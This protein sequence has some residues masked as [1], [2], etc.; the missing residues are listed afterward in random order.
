MA[1]QKI[2]RSLP[3]GLR[4]RDGYYSYRDPVDGKEYGLGRNKREAVAQAM[5]AN[6][7][8]RT[9]VSL[10][11]RINGADMTWSNWC[12]TFEKLRE[13]RKRSDNTIRQDRSKMNRLRKCFGS[14]RSA[15]GITTK[16]VAAVLKAIKAEGK[17][18]MAQSF[19]SFLI[20]CFDRMVAQG[21]RTDNP[22]RVTDTIDVEVKRARLTLEV[23]MRVY[24]GTELAWL[25]NAMA[26]ALVSGQDRDSIAFAEFS[27]FRDGFWWNERSKTKARIKIPLRV[28]LDVFGMSLEEVLRQCRQTG[29][30]SRHPVHQ[31]ERGKGAR[32]GKKMHEDTITRTFTAEIL[33]LGI[34]W[35]KKTHPTFYEIRSL[36]TRLY[37]MQRS[38]VN[39]KAMATEGKGDENAE[40]VEVTIDD[41]V[42][43][44][45]LLGHTEAETTEIYRD[46]RGEWVEADLGSKK[47]KTKRKPAP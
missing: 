7:A 20:D 4:E 36:A 41:G 30:V 15:K 42:N 21:V 23:F 35:G 46:G 22:V 32:V 45:E 9:T 11:D 8:R 13:E 19:R 16:D 44:Q 27:D 14:D 3:P 37:D 6:H 39:T 38:G 33:K 47:R 29:F 1:R 26:L 10:L 31:T 28:R 5:E 34:D 2:D 18:R 40:W 24:Q 25:R 12:D 17:Q 43:T